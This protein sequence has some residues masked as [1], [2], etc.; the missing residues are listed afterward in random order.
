MGCGFRIGAGADAVASAGSG[1]FEAG[2]EFAHEEFSYLSGAADKA[3][4]DDVFPL[5]CFYFGEDVGVLVFLDL[6]VQDFYFGVF[7]ER[8]DHAA[9][10]GDELAGRGDEV[11]LQV[12]VAVEFFGPGY[13]GGYVFVAGVDFVDLQEPG[14]GFADFLLFYVGVGQA[15]AQFQGDVVSDFFVA[16]AQFEVHGGSVHLPF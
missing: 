14:Q 11:Y 7:V 2:V 5:G 10:E 12:S 9:A 16:E 1:L 13:L 4:E 3:K 8:H 6:D 15:V